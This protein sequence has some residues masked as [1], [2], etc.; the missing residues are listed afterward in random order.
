MWQRSPAQ[1]ILE[2]CRVVGDVQ[3]VVVNLSRFGVF[4]SLYGS[5]GR[6]KARCLVHIQNLIDFA[7]PLCIFLHHEFVADTALIMEIGWVIRFRFD[8]LT[9]MPD[10]AADVT[11][12]IGIF[13][14]PDF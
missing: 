9:Q 14:T 5:G 12:L 3:K 4:R 11:N 10:V 2:L 13:V 8:L 7:L 1:A 6:I